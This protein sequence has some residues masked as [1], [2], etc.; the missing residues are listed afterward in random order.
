MEASINEFD[1]VEIDMPGRPQLVN[2][3]EYCCDVLIPRRMMYDVITSIL[4]FVRYFLLA[5]VSQR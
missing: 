3:S 1:K 5:T 4:S 2:V